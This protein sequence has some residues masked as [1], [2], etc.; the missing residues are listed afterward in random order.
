M[1]QQ[2]IIKKKDENMSDNL[3]LKLIRKYRKE[4]YC[5]GKLYVGDKYFCDTR[6]SE[7]A[8]LYKGQCI[9]AKEEQEQYA[10]PVGTYSINLTS[11]SFTK[12]ML[13][14]NPQKA[15]IKFYAPGFEPI[16]IPNQDYWSDQYAEMLI[17]SGHRMEFGGPEQ[18]FHRP[19]SYIRLGFNNE[20]GKVNDTERVWTLLMEKHLIPAVMS[21]RGISIE[22]S[23]EYEVNI[24]IEKYF[25]STF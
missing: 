7:D 8:G 15:R 11:A 17:E 10:C 12:E 6:E 1:T 13:K 3:K 2:E 5:I 23:R 21:G 19:A 9:T 18:E 22:I 14:E 24:E 4:R 20:P 16:V 25:Y